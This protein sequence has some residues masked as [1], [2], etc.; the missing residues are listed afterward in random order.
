[1]KIAIF[2]ILGVL[3]R[4][5]V[6]QFRTIHRLGPGLDRR[7]FHGIPPLSTTGYKLLAIGYRLLA[8]RAW[9]GLGTPH[10]TVK[11]LN[12][13]RPWDGGTPYLPPGQEKVNSSPFGARSLVS[14][15]N[16]LLSA[17]VFSLAPSEAKRGF[18]HRP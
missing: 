12:V 4:N 6:K 3:E 18:S 15:F 8:G 2:I 11:I 13:C 14:A 1:M 9:D 5:L 7:E 16:L 17:F 10:G